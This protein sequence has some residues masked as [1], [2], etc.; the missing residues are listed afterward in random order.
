MKTT[1]TMNKMISHYITAKNNPTSNIT[2]GLY[3]TIF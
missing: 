3:Q 1:T 2:I